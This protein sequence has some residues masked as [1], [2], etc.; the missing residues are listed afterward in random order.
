MPRGAHGPLIADP[1]ML[2]T[3]KGAF[4]LLVRAMV[5]L[6]RELGL[7]VHAEGV[8]TTAQATALRDP[9]YT[10]GQGFLYAPPLLPDQ[11]PAFLMR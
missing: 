7:A 6:G 10:P 9:G 11:I 5:A 1:G 8:E 2:L 3:L 4:A